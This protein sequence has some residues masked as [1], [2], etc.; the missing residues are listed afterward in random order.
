MEKERFIFLQE[1][2]ALTILVLRF[3]VEREKEREKFKEEK[4]YMIKGLFIAE[5]EPD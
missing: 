4:H 5:T 3:I 1:P 2:K